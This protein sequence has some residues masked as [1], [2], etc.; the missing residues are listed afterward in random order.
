MHL[1]AAMFF[2]DYSMTP[3]ELG[4]ALEQLAPEQREALLL[5]VVEG[6]SYADAFPHQIACDGARIPTLAELFA[7]CEQAGAKVGRPPRYNLEIKSDPRRPVLTPAPDLLADLVVSQVRASQLATRIEIQSFDWRVVVAAKKL[8]PDITTGCLTMRSPDSDTIDGTS[9]HPS[10]WLAGLVPEQHG[11]SIPRMIESTGARRWSPW[12]RNLTADD[13]AEA[14]ALGL[15][16]VP[17]TVNEAADM[18]HLVAMGIDGLIT[19]YPDRAL[20]VL[21]RLDVPVA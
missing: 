18:E 4:R 5:V 8:A 7:T 1:G 16:V 3:G 15:R 17:W 10:P 21:R 11:G 19:D 6:T 13:L 20:S 9:A 12:Y 2:T 14:H